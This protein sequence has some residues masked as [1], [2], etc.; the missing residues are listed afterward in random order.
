ML[1][2]Y[3]LLWAEDQ[4]VM[5]SHAMN[6]TMTPENLIQDLWSALAPG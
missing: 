5:P 6:E 1:V 3:N 2:L 4:S